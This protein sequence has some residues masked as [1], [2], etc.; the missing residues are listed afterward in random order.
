MSENPFSRNEVSKII[1]DGTIIDS[2][3]IWI[4]FIDIMSQPWALFGYNYFSICNISLSVTWKDFILLLILH[5]EEGRALAVFISMYIKANEIIEK[6][7]Y[8]TKTRNIKLE[9]LECYHQRV[10]ETLL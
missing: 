7:C 6:I 5:E 8:D 3:Q 1:F 9:K 4:I 2:P 10:K